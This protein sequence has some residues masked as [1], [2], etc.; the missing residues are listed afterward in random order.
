MIG[1]KPD[2]SF[3]LT[4]PA[5]V[6]DV[7]QIAAAARAGGSFIRGEFAV[8]VHKDCRRFIGGAVGMMMQMKLP[9]QLSRMAIGAEPLRFAAPTWLTLDT[10]GK[11]RPDLPSNE[12]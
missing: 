9:V 5:E 7:A 8:A 2:R 1:D 10:A 12:A 4:P 3:H 11:W 6:D